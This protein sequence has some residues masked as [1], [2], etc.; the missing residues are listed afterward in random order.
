MSGIAAAARLI[1]SGFTG[2]DIVI[3]E[4]SNRIGGRVNTKTFG[5][6]T[7]FLFFLAVTYL[8]LDIIFGLN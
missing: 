1:A 6:L 2:D 3:L 7:N 5:E 8:I 4:A